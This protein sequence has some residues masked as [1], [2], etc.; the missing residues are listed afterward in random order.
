[1]REGRTG[2]FW[3]V[4]CYLEKVMLL[5]SEYAWPRRHETSSLAQPSA[6][7][8]SHAGSCLDK[9]MADSWL[10]FARAGLP[11]QD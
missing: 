11:L 5:V 4:L 7:V 3:Q 8:C 6:V 2:N 1:M 9:Q 10:E